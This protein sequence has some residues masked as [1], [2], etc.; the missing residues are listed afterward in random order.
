MA[1]KRKGTYVHPN[2]L[3]RV[4]DEAQLLDFL[5]TRGF[6]TLVAVT[7][8]GLKGA[9][10]PFVVD[11]GKR[12]LRFHL[13]RGNALVPA[14]TEGTQAFLTVN[15]PDA[16]ISPD[17]YQS[18]DQVPTWNYVAVH[19]QGSCGPLAEEDLPV[20]LDDLSAMREERLLPKTPWTRAKMTP[21][22]DE[23]MRRAILPFEFRITSLEGTWKLSQN[24]E[25][26]DYDGAVAGLEARGDAMSA[27]VAGLMKHD[28]HS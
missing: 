25:G 11:R 27:G 20:L 26:A 28:S 17:W 8:E 9:S 14:L 7:D 3:F 5:V 19:V 1:E 13:A 15:G 6:G 18:P 16:Y 10:I 23:R 22:R 24:K 21:E 12:R 4:S 2:K